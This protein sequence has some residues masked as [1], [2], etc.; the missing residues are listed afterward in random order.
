VPKKAK[1]T[2]ARRKASAPRFATVRSLVR[3]AT[4]RFAKAKLV[5]GQGTHA[6]VE[7]AIFLVYETLGLPV[8]RVDSHLS[9]KVTAAEHKRVL[10]LIETRVR[11]RTPAA[12]LLKRAWLQGL[13][14]H[15]DERVIVPRSYLAELLNG[16][17][18][19]AGRALVDAA[20]VK[21]VLDLC[22]G[23]GCLAVLACHV[24]PNAQVD[25]VD[26]S[27]DALDVAAVNVA[28]HK[29]NKCITLYRGD[30]FA[31]LGDAVYD[32]IV[33]NPPY[34]DAKAMAALP[35][36]YAKEPKMALAGG[37]DGLDIVRRILH[38]APA[39][40]S[41]HGGL[42]CEVGRGRA[43]LERDYPDLRFLWLDSEESTG[44]VF[45]IS[46]EHLKH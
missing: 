17:L 20:K 3:Y 44:E 36:E 23:S 25:A 12:Y 18:F 27:K 42:L 39:H 7:E 19:Q 28:Q 15:V 30:L 24:F 8:H 37:R 41:A 21:R 2:V 13:S 43:I 26:L 11:S 16:E 29:L 6:P 46:A 4:M 40:L 33:T 35:E 14:F 34:V 9:R 5:F 10:A 32:I 22:T 45:W 38:E 31:P 1:R